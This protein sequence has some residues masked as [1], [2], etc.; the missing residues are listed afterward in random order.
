MRGIA[1]AAVKVVKCRP[2]SKLRPLKLPA[3]L[4]HKH[5]WDVAGTWFQGGRQ[6]TQYF[7]GDLAECQR[8]G[9][10]RPCRVSRV[11][12]DAKPHDG[13]FRVKFDADAEEMKCCYK[14]L[15]KVSKPHLV[16]WPPWLSSWQ[17]SEAPPDPRC[18][19]H[20]EAGDGTA[21]T[22]WRHGEAA[23][24]VAI[25]AAERQREAAQWQRWEQ[26]EAERR[27]ERQRQR[28]EFQRYCRDRDVFL[29]DHLGQDDGSE[30]QDTDHEEHA[31]QV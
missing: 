8:E 19:D 17:P 3:K 14:D 26:E 22:P 1:M 2:F 13:S 15:R 6:E 25:S 30:G 29:K 12:S 23:E 21:A 5:A 31:S 16:P 20:L 10:W 11:P 27:A 7:L 9:L 28:E 24:A 18:W 4:R